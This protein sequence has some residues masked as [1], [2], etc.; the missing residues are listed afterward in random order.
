MESFILLAVEDV[1]M[2][3]ALVLGG[4]STLRILFMKLAQVS[5]VF[6]NDEHITFFFLRCNCF[7]LYYLVAYGKNKNFFFLFFF[8]SIFYLVIT[9]GGRVYPRVIRGVE[10]C[11]NPLWLLSLLWREGMPNWCT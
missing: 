5:R 3:S 1:L 6:L 2:D 11:L 7:E 4:D 8:S 10:Q 9:M